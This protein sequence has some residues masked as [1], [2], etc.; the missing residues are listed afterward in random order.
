MNLIGVGGTQ[1]RPWGDEYEDEWMKL[2]DRW[3]CL[4]MPNMDLCFITSV[5]CVDEE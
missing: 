1:D 5:C 2:E 3:F 4:T